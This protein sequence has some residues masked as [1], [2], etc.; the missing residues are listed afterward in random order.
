MYP[1]S[2]DHEKYN[3]L[4]EVLSLYRLTLGQPQQEEL[5]ETIKKSNW[6]LAQLKKLYINLSPYTR[7][8]F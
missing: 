3:R 1:Y 5:L 6:D 7:L 2:R 8:I 4:L